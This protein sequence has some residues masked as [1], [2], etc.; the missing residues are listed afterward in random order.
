M[1]GS[2]LPRGTSQEV[3]W[4]P[5]GLSC[6]GAWTENGNSCVGIEF[7]IKNEILVHLWWLQG[8][9]HSRDWDLHDYG[10][11]VPFMLGAGPWRLDNVLEAL[12]GLQ[13]KGIL[14]TQ[15]ITCIHQPSSCILFLS[16]SG[17]ARM[18]REIANGIQWDERIEINRRLL[19][20][21]IRP[22]DAPLM[23]LIS[24]T[25]IKSTPR[26]VL[27]V[28]KISE[29]NL[30]HKTGCISTALPNLSSE[31]RKALSAT[32]GHSKHWENGIVF[33]LP[34][35]PPSLFKKPC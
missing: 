22:D 10:R 3:N 23:G 11:P 35:G 20:H 24:I 9:S 14:Q 6:D 17:F 19:F 21:Q 16:I 15:T 1:S 30:F 7:H 26:V 33:L 28:L 32:Y 29:E 5:S 13:M 18:G 4:I 8:T 12:W 31:K 25:R 27:I 34:P 2:R